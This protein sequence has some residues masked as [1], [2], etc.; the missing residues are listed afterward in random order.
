MEGYIEDF[1]QTDR[2]SLEIGV[3]LVP[4]V[5]AGRGPGLVDRIGGLRR[6]LARQNGLWVPAV[7]VRDN[8]ELDP[9]GYRVLVG[10]REVA[11]G[12]VRPDQ[13]LAI[14]PGQAARIALEGEDT[15]EP[16]FGLPAKWIPDAERS[17]AE[18]GG[19]TVVDAPS[20][21]ITHLGEV[22]RRHASELL[23]RDDLKAMLEKVRAASPAIVDEVI[24]NVVT[25]GTLHRVVTNLLTERVPVS[26]LTRILESLA[27]HA[28]TVKDPADLTERVRAGRVRAIVLDPRLE[29]ELRRT[30][31]G[32]QLAL[33]P[34]RLEQ[35]T[36]KLA[37]LVRQANRAGQDVALL[38]DS[39]LRRAVR[40]ALGRAL[41]DLSVI[42]YQEIPTDLLM[43]PVAVVR[44]DD[45]V[46]GSPPAVAAALA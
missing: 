34:A 22:V 25:A 21:V 26:N 43:E 44:A 38:C 29:V 10:G 20:V 42:A 18:I 19:Y 1:L 40:H 3:A 11:R 36:L 2:V 31:Q 16:T 39:S 27:A 23:S 14:D 30:A 32:A 13:W 7:R 24:P 4:L 12:A 17:R 45:L 5:S 8:I 6:D 33:D 35:L 46:G 28:P 41:P 15:V 37:A 9:Q